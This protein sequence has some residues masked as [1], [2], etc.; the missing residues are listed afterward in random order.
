MMKRDRWQYHLVLF[1]LALCAP[2]VHGQT[3]KVK[4][5]P[6]ADVATKTTNAQAACQA[7]LPCVLIFEP[8]IAGFPTG[9]MPAPCP[10]CTWFNYTAVAGSLGGINAASYPIYHDTQYI[11][12]ATI[13]NGQNTILC[14]NG[15]CN[16][17]AADNG[18]VCFASN[19]TT[20]ISQSASVI[21]L[22]EG[23]LTVTGAQTATCSGGN[24]TQNAVGVAYL[25][26][27][28]LDTAAAGATQNATT[29]PIFAAWT[30]AQTQCKP[31]LLP[32]GVYL[33]ERGEFNTYTAASACGQISGAAA[34]RRG[35]SIRGAGPTDTILIVT[36]NMPATDCTGP[37]ATGN[38]CYLS[39]PDIFIEGIQLW[40]AGNSD[41]GAGFAGKAG[42]YISGANPGLNAYIRDSMFLGW[43]AARST[44]VGMQVGDGTHTLSGVDFN[45]VVIETIGFPSMVINMGCPEGPGQGCNVMFEEG[46]LVACNQCLDLKNGAFRTSKAW[47]GGVGA[48]TSLAIDNML[49]EGGR[50]YSSSDTIPYPVKAGSALVWVTGVGS[51]FRATGSYIANTAAGSYGLRVS[52]G[53]TA[54]L[55]N[56]ALIQSA[57]PALSLYVEPGSTVYDLGGN[58]I[59]GKTVAGTY[60][61]PPPALT[62][63]GTGQLTQCNGTTCTNDAWIAAP[64]TTHSPVGGFYTTTQNVTVGGCAGGTSY[65]S[66]NGGAATAYSTPVAVSASGY[67]TSRCELVHYNNSFPLTSN[68]IIAGMYDVFPGNAATDLHTSNAL[69]VYNANS[70]KIDGAGNAYGTLGT[71]NLAHRSDLTGSQIYAEAIINQHQETQGT[72]VAVQATAATYT[73]YICVIT[74]TST[75][76]LYKII[77]GTFTSI[78]STAVTWAEGDMLYIDADVTGHTQNCKQLHNGSVVANVAGADAAISANGSPGLYASSGSGT[79]RISKF[80][81]GTG[82]IH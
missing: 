25:F 24:A 22:P 52:S 46:Q 78:N 49:V 67:L 5:F 47:I 54:T 20:D 28:H 66:L 44:F 19:A 81:A 70:F 61:G 75:M 50:W 12:D 16:F 53:A 38:G 2:I 37:N 26:W 33:L 36:P 14:P 58:V 7:G 40:G 21:I 56:M 45:N 74:S 68:Y 57:T 4:E 59:T 73:A 42:V 11:T 3:L 17:T 62:G 23:T 43:G 55:S 76:T 27:G 8:E 15:D 31:L 34:Q 60:I 51:E 71:V 69:W 1:V 13:A 63:T 80:Q 18:K 39:V 29:D 48:T 64:I 35:Y 30:D 79:A 6:G 41:P 82:T 9:T 65:Y 77:T 10:A 72:G 32:A